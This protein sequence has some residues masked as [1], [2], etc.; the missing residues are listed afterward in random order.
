M[1]SYLQ[2]KEKFLW[3]AAK[4]GKV[5]LVENDLA[6]GVDVNH[7]NSNEVIRK[8]IGYCWTVLSSRET[9]FFNK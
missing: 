2:S 9:F 8:N 5:S 4:N 7:K 6:A 3:F 1:S